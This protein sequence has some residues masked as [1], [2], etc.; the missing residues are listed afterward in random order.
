TCALPI[1]NVRHNVAQ[2]WSSTVP[3]AREKR[4]LHIH[5]GIA[6]LRQ[7][8]T[9][10]SCTDAQAVGGLLATAAFGPQGIEDQ[11]EFAPTQVLAQ[12]SG[13]LDGRS[14]FRAT[15]YARSR[16]DLPA[17]RDRSEAARRIQAEILGPNH[18]ALLQD[19]RA[20]DGVVQFAN[21]TRPGMAGQAMTSLGR[22]PGRRLAHLL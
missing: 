8:V 22:K 11:L 9:Q 3:S 10:G 16:F 15:Q 4:C 20:L 21:V 19:Q 2:G 18:A 14:A 12:R 17:R 1:S 7:L 6:H 5:P 13:R